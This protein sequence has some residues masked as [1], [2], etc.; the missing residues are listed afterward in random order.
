MDGKVE[1]DM[2]VVGNEQPPCGYYMTGEKR[3]TT[4]VAKLPTV[5]IGP[6]LPTFTGG[7]DNQFV[8]RKSI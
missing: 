7:F 1:K 8:Q 6:L 3:G 4:K 5:K 2:H